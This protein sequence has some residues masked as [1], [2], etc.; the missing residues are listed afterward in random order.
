MSLTLAGGE[1]GKRGCLPLVVAIAAVHSLLTWGGFIGP[2]TLACIGV[3]WFGDFWFF[4]SG[5]LAKVRNGV[6]GWG[7]S[8]GGQL[9][10]F[11]SC[12]WVL[13]RLGGKFRSSSVRGLLLAVAFH[14]YL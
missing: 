10:L 9:S 11:L 4:S 7:G 14:G 5:Y 6:V 1:M 13:G 2:W 3:G 12:C 8:V